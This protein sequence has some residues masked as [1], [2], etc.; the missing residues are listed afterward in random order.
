MAL[1]PLIDVSGCFDGP[2]PRRNAVTHQIDETFRSVGFLVLT[3]HGVASDT[4]ASA[5][6]TAHE[7]MALPD[8]E[9]AR[10]A[11]PRLDIF[12]GYNGPTQRSGNKYRTDAP[13]D[14]RENYMMSRIDVVDPYFRRPEFG[15]TYAPNIW[16][17]R[18]A[19]YRAVW[20]RFYGEMSGLAQRFMRLCALALEVEEKF[21]ADKTDKCSSTCVAN[22]YPAQPAEPR[23][24]QVRAAAHS[25]VGSVTLLLQ[26]HAI[27]GLQILGKDGAWHD[28]KTERDQVI[29]NVGDLLAQWTNDRWVSTKHR[30]IN[31]PREFAH[32]DRMSLSFFQHPNY[33]ALVECL[34]SCLGPGNPARYPPITAGEHMHR[35]M[36]L[37]RDWSK[38]NSNAA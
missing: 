9:K 30:V 16:P 19:E 37:A 12:R 17:E 1:V 24:G 26:E 35:R 27:G 10:S 29:V 8:A 18:P 13:P 36:M 25:D 2:G 20:E 34:P 15:N 38:G 14:L 31:P 4:I 28:V 11:P 7:F 3:G 23:P 32:T 22:H 33:D 21:F 6:R 5:F